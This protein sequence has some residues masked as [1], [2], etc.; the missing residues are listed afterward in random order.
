MC[1]NEGCLCTGV[2][3]AQD[4]FEDSWRRIVSHVFSIDNDNAGSLNDSEVKGVMDCTWLRLK[5][6][7]FIEET[8]HRLQEEN[9]ST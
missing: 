8:M 7:N 3:K 6:R 4:I 1:G 2:S 5:A 9:P